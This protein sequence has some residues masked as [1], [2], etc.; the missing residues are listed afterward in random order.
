MKKI[1]FK[2]LSLAAAFFVAMFSVLVYKPSDVSVLSVFDN[3]I[4]VYAENEGESL[5]DLDDSS[6]GDTGTNE[7]DT[8][9]KKVTD[10]FI[11]WIKRIGY[12]VAFIGGVMFALAVKNNDAE[13]KQSALLTMVSGFIL[14]ALCSIATTI[15]K[16]NG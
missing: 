5:D 8:A 12:F 15:F 6:S 2:K 7:G 10:F 9:W 13:A 4:T 14:V 1:I 16:I 3:S 11:V